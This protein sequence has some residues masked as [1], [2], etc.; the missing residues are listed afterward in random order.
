MHAALVQSSLAAGQAFGRALSADDCDRYVA[1]MMVAAELVGVPR[2]LIPASVAELDRY[3]ASVQPELRCTPA[4]RESMAYLLDPPGLDQELAGFWQDVRDG[5]IAVLPEWAREMYGYAAP[6][7]PPLAPGRRTEI[8]QSLGVLD[9]LFL[10]EPGVLEAR[11]RITL[12][13][14]AARSA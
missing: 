3:V 2:L 5:A 13:M 8:R 11:Q 7:P 9:A 4:A 14:R 12:R 6:Q 1:E 10:S